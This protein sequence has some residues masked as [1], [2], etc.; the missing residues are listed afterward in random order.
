MSDIGYNVDWDED[1][2]TI[3]FRIRDITARFGRGPRS[4]KVA[5]ERDVFRGIDFTLNAY[6][7]DNYMNAS[8]GYNTHWSVN[9]NEVR[10]TILDLN[11]DERGRNNRGRV[12]VAWMQQS[13]GDVVVQ[14]SAYRD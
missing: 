9:G 2:D 11:Y 6:E 13:I 12:K 8:N 3:T 5:F 1:D 4:E 10:V 7:P 14:L